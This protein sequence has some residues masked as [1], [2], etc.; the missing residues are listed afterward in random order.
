[1][2]GI[3][4]GLQTNPKTEFALGMKQDVTRYILTCRSVNVSVDI[5]LFLLYCNIIMEQ[6]ELLA[7]KG[8]VISRVVTGE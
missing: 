5:K 2:H 6:A 3:T 1:M 4:R 7:G 8:Y